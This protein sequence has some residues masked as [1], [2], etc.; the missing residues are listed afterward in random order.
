ML[1]QKIEMYY[2]SLNY[3]NLYNKNK[4]NYSLIKA[5]ECTNINT[6]F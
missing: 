5:N 4:Y 2:Y 1:N 6:S 3:I